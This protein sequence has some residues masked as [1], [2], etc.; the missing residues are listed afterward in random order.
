ML[1]RNLLIAL[2]VGAATAA[3]A[4]WDVASDFSYTDNPNGTWNYGTY[5]DDGTFVANTVQGNF[6]GFA[7]GWIGFGGAG[8]PFVGMNDTGD[9]YGSH[10][11]Q[12]ILHADYPG[13]NHN[14]AGVHWISPISGTVHV[15]GTFYEGDSNSID[16]FV[17][18]NRSSY[19]ATAIDQ[20]ADF[21]F[22]FDQAVNAGDFL[23]FFIGPNSSGE[24]SATTTPFDL[25]ISNSAVPEPASMSALGF[26][27]LVL[28][29]RRKRA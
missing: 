9:A 11:G 5:Q 23:D 28:I 13:S 18:I 1:N 22:E 3:H 10:L 6:F 29:R 20:F 15:K 16:A 14:Y 12:V 27:A 21:N 8:R 26:G 17:S 25:H 7:D 2:L 24:P 19:I 4:D